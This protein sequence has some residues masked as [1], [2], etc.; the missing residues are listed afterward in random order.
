MSEAKWHQLNWLK[1]RWMVYILSF[2]IPIFGWITFWVFSGRDARLQII[3][4][5]AMIASF[6][7]IILLI[8]LTAVGIT[9]FSIPLGVFPG[10]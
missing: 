10:T 6:I 8:I 5:G 7:G 3:A 2:F 1:V 9:M 4:R